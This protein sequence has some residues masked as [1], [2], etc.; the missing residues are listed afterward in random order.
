MVEVLAKEK[1]VGEFLGEEVMEEGEEEVV[2]EEVVEEEEEG[3]EVVGEEVVEEEGE[4]VLGE[5]VVEE[6]EGE[7]V[8]DTEIMK[9]YHST[10]IPVDQGPDSTDKL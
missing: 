9:L 3:D 7:E 2:A 1:E 5:E 8:V 4:E 6:E 10:A